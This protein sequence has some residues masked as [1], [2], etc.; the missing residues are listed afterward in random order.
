M[1]THTRAR[2]HTPSSPSTHTR[3][4]KK[5]GGEQEEGGDAAQSNDVVDRQTHAAAMRAPTRLVKYV[6]N[7]GAEW[8]RAI[9][10]L[11]KQLAA[12]PATRPPPR[13]HETKTPPGTRPATDTSP[14]RHP[15]SGAPATPHAAAA[16][17][18]QTLSPGGS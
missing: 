5:V 7:T 16:P 17:A 15:T 14:T 6:K 1:L 2:T 12:P 13:L 11:E 8:S 9:H 4:H 10:R 18:S 3:R